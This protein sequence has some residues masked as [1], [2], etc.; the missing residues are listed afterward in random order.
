MHLTL[1]ATGVDSKV[2]LFQVQIDEKGNWAYESRAVEKATGKLMDGDVAQLRSLYEK[3]P[4]D[5]EVLNNPVSSDDRTLFKLEVNREDGD[6]R[7]Y[8]FSEAM[9]HLSWQFRDLVHFLRHNVANHG[10]PV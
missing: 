4:W 10:D 6:K 5:Q 2:D 1:S 9:N 3:V 7:L 8:Q